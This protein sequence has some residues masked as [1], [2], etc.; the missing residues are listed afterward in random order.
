M[1]PCAE[2][3]DRSQLGLTSLVQTVDQQ[4][5]LVPDET[6]FDWNQRH[7]VIE[8]VRIVSHIDDQIIVE[9]FLGLIAYVTKTNKQFSLRGG[10]G[11]FELQQEVVFVA[12]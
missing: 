2:I 8:V 12:M 6:I 1:D 11:F 9:L 5:I 10:D 7:W 3:I 4:R